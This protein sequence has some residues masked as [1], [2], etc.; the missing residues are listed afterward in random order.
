MLRDWLGTDAFK[1]PLDVE[2]LPDTD[3]V[4]SNRNAIRPVAAGR[5]ILHGS[6]HRGIIPPSRFAIEIDAA[7][8]FGTGHHATTAGCLTVLDRLVRTR[9]YTN[10]LDLGTGSGV[11]AI[12]LAKALRRPVLASDVDPTAVAIAR[13]NARLNGVGSLV[14]CVQAEGVDAAIRRRAPF[15]LVVA[16]IL[17]EPL[18]RLA[19]RVAPLI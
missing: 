16:N 13:D 7:R 8:A 12:A 2:V 19:P 4:A 3:W 6:H 14:R 15:D 5:F 17:A 9:R 10:P 11:L 18:M 1:A